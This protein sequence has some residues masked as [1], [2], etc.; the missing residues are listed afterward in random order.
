MTKIREAAERL[1]PQ[2]LR[3]YDAA[4]KA[5]QFSSAVDSLMNAIRAKLLLPGGHNPLT[6]L[7]QP[8]STQLHGLSDKECAQQAQATRLVLTAL[9]ENVAVVL[10]D[11][12]ELMA[13]ASSLQKG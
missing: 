6:V 11:Q 3:L 1:G 7:H 9:L 13:A 8:L 2:D 12:R 10:K 5:T 4:L